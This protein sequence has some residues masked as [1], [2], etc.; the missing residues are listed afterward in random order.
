MPGESMQA[1]SKLWFF[2]DS[3]VDDAISKR[4]GHLVSN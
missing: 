4:F 2:G 1:K 3:E